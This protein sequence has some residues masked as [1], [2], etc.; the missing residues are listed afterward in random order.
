M[1][2]RLLVGLTLLLTLPAL[3]A[4]RR[5]ANFIVQAPTQEI[6]D[7]IATAAEQQRKDQALAWLGKELPPWDAPCPVHVEVSMACPGGATSF[8][9]APK[10]GVLWQKMELR[11]PLDRLLAGVLP[12]EVAHTIFAHH[13][14]RPVPRWAD[15][16]GAVM[17]EDRQ[18]H[19]RHGKIMQQALKACRQWPLRRLFAREDFPADRAALCTFYGQSYSVSHFLIETGGRPK[20]LDFVKRGYHDGWDE[21]A[22]A[23]YQYRDVEALE[24][25]W[26]GWVRQK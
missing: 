18:E 9:F 22:Q 1:H 4:S 20:F 21:A 10:G 5:T 2:H 23:V 7:R 12:H 16:G 11:G 26:L 14:G 25:A 19:E 24:R 8:R 17:T 3:G 15:E 13:V 6:A